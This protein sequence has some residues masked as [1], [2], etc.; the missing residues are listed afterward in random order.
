LCV[1]Y[2]D[3]TAPA[4]TLGFASIEPSALLATGS[5][6]QRGLLFLH[7]LTGQNTNTCYFVMG[8][9]RS[10]LGHKAIRWVA[11][12]HHLRLQFC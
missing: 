4:L 6:G 8:Y 9:L 3:E 12:L 11:R 10:S 2:S 5:V 1:G 7:S